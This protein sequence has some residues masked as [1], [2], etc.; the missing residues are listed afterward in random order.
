MNVSQLAR[1]LVSIAVLVHAPGAAAQ[2][3][4]VPAEPVMPPPIPM[5]MPV[6]P[7][8]G[9]AVAP[10][11]AAAPPAESETVLRTRLKSLKMTVGIPPTAS[12]LGSE[13]DMV[14]T[15]GGEDD[16]TITA[17]LANWT[18][19][20]KGYIRAPMRV[21]IGPRFNENDKTELHSPPRIVG[22]GSGDWN[23]IA[24]APNP[25]ASLY[26]KAGNPVVSANI[27]FNANTFYDSG[28]RDLDQMGGIS[29]AYLTLKFPRAFGSTGG[30]A[31]TVGSFSNRYG[32]AG[33][34]QSNSGYYGTYLFGR[35]HVAGE[36]L[37]ADFDLTDHLELVLEHGIGSK[38]E[39]IPYVGYD[40]VADSAPPKNNFLPGQGSVPQGTNLLHH[41]HVGLLIDNWFKLGLHAMTS[42]S[43][44][45]NNTLSNP[46]ESRM[47]V[48]GADVHVD[49]SVAGHAYLGYSHIKGENLLPLADAIQVLHGSNGKGFKEDYFG[50]KDR[51]TNITATNSSGTVDSIL[52]QYLL[53]L[54]P[55][56][57][58]DLPM[59]DI[60]LSLY[61]MFNHV[62]SPVTD[63]AQAASGLQRDVKL[64]KLKFGA[65]VEL[66]LL[67][68]MAMGFRYDRV[69]PDLTDTS[70]LYQAL[71][72]RLIF[73]SNWRSKEYIIVDYT[74]FLL[75]PKAY[76]GSP[77]TT[78]LKSDP[79]MIMVSAI[80]SF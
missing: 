76:P 12:D 9:G 61:G 14:S 3:A 51:D 55:V 41:G 16:A 47:T 25:T 36:V 39:P 23:Y 34:N 53:H 58:E 74:H 1:V 68:F 15:T 72:P 56:F 4:E 80:M 11:V 17:Q 77:Y 64:D 8:N 20:M 45:D 24:L 22:L 50:P 65:E 31:W 33:A 48:V 67:K 66:A 10:Q 63:P 57:G 62:R 2:A 29:Q 42:W 32:N 37:T 44:D 40:L 7:S 52:W 43:P 60:T 46:P 13:A 73:H 21:G 27:I 26:I 30:V 79:D 54:A 49:D 38:I 71:S 70:S 6:P 35:T 5:P 19:G 28:Y 18:L 69:Q 59:H 78:Y 75:G